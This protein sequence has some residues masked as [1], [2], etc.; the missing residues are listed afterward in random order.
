MKRE[1][2]TVEGPIEH[3]Y[4]G[5]MRVDILKQHVNKGAQGAAAAIQAATGNM[6]LAAT[7]ASVAMA[8]T[9]EQMDVF[10][11]WVGDHMIQGLLPYV[12]FKN[13]D[14]VKVVFEQVGEEK[15]MRAIWRTEDDMLWMPLMLGRGIWPVTKRAIKHGGW[16]FLTTICLPLIYVYFSKDELSD[17]HK[18]IVIYG[19]VGLAIAMGIW[20]Y[21][22]SRYQGQLSTN[23]FKALGLTNP[24]WLDLRPYS[25]LK[26]K[27]DLKG[28]CVYDLKAMRAAKKN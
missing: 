7:S 24:T 10:G 14:D 21:F 11:F 23:V 9:D 8:D 5:K 28:E 6:G 25:L 22:A 26:L 12:T 13:D 4:T 17:K 16:I 15:Q 19:S 18:A 2:Q 20:D 3:L 1:L 27:G